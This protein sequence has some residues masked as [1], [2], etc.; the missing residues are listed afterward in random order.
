VL[1]ALGDADAVGL[2]ERPERLAW[3][4]EFGYAFAIAGTHLQ[5][6]LLPE[7]R[8]RLNVRRELNEPR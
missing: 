4:R 2:A 6:A 3:L 5:D 1:V 8:A 7:Q